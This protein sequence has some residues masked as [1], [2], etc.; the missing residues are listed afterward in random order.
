MIVYL[1]AHTNSAGTG[2]AQAT[3]IADNPGAAIEAFQEQYPER[4][5]SALGIRGEGG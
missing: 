4:K 1:I 3:I 2:I 5:Y